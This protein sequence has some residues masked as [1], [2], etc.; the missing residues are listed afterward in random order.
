MINELLTEA[1][2]LRQKLRNQ[3]DSYET[4]IRELRLK[5]RS[6]SEENMQIVTECQLK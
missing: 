2:Q 6:L 3:K 5:V 4:T 1:T